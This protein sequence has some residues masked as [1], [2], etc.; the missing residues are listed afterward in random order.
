MSFID[1]LTDP[2]V[3]LA[4]ALYAAGSAIEPFVE[5]WLERRVADNA[6]LHWSWQH[7]GVP[8]MR[9]ALV[10]GFVFLAYPALFGL[11][12][13]PSLQ[14]LLAAHDAAPSTV[15][16]VLYLIALLAP[17]LPLFHRHP[18]LVLP[19]QG[20]LAVAFVFHWLADYLHITVATAWPGPATAL[21][22]AGTA[23]L[24]HRVAMRVG[25]GV[26]AGIDGVRGTRGYDSL[27]AHV[28]TLLAQLPVV[29]IYSAGLGTQ[30]GF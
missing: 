9:A 22:M 28:V 13:A 12:E 7:L 10:L 8:L 29:L 15:L 30:L 26:G 25:E 19:L 20:A 3:L 16:G 18:E 17:V 14:A 1:V 5:G 2:R 4:A 23:W 6:P 21:A 27:G 24:L 11:R